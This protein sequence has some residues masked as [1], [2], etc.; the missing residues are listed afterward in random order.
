[1]T[2]PNE[3]PLIR[4]RDVAAMLG[5]AP[6]TLYDLRRRGVLPEPIALSPKLKGY[7]RS[8]IEAVLRG[9]SQA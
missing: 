3:D 8:T 7:R 6:R 9:G 1:M 4:L 5:V 2:I